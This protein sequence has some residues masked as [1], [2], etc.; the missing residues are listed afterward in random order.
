M[1]AIVTN[2]LRQRKRKE[3]IGVKGQGQPLELVEKHRNEGFQGSAGR[4]L[5]QGHHFEGERLELNLSPGSRKTV[6]SKELQVI[7]VGRGQVK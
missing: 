3:V 7:S 6:F 1:N 4:K 2:R 5:S